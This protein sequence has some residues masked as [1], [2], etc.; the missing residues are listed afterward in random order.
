MERTKKQK[1]FAEQAKVKL[2]EEI[3]N[4]DTEAAHWQADV[5]LTSLLNQL[6]FNDVVELYERVEKWYA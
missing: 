3:N 5:V 1:E 6:G 2:I 4:F